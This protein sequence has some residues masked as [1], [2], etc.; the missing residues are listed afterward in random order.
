MPQCN[1]E[2]DDGW[3]DCHCTWSASVLLN[4]G[5]IYASTSTALISEKKEHLESCSWHR[6]ENY[7]HSLF[8]IAHSL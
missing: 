6:N 8:D 5:L 3:V 7:Y 1:I 2:E 4:L